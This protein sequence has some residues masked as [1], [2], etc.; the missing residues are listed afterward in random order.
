MEFLSEYG[1]FLAKTITFVLAFAAVVVIAASAAMNQQGDEKGQIEVTKLNDRFAD[2]GNATKSAI[3]TDE[4]LKDEEKQNKKKEKAEKKAK[5]KADKTES[6]EETPAKKRVFV[7]DFDGDVKASATEELREVVTAILSIANEKDE[8]VVRLE[9]PGGM[10][11]GYGLAASQLAR[12]GAKNIPLTICVDKVAASGGYMMACVG[13]KIVSAPFAVIGSI[14]VVAQLPN[15]HRLLK[16]HDV[17]YEMFTAGK[18][19]RTVTML[20]ENTEEGKEKFKEDIEDTHV[21]FKDFIQQNREQVDVEEVATGEVWFGTRALEQNLVDQIGTSDEYLYELSQEADLY[22][23]TFEHKMNVETGRSIYVELN[24][25]IIPSSELDRDPLP[26]YVPPFSKF[27]PESFRKTGKSAAVNLEFIISP[28]GEVLNPKI[29]S[30]TTEGFEKA[31]LLAISSMK[32][33]PIEQDGKAVYV[34]M[35]RP[36]QLTE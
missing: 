30:I 33:R 29:L 25:P 12:F 11:H 22:E 21:L 34:S 24:G 32:Y 36:I 27:Y 31:A 15:F 6:G 18:Y 4:Q 9:S 19:K 28:K 2:L 1:L 35:I 26:S 3:L 20:G 23:V 16:K 10:V 17:D 5:K 14:G 8:V 13:E 7:T